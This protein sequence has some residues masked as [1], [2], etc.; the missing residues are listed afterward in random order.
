MSTP[1][2]TKKR[3][4][5][6]K[7]RAK[8]K[9][10]PRTTIAVASYVFPPAD[11][12]ADQSSPQ[13]EATTSEESDEIETLLRNWSRLHSMIESK[14]RPPVAESA[15]PGTPGGSTIKS[16]RTYANGILGCAE[17]LGKS[18]ETLVRRLE[19][20]RAEEARRAR[21]LEQENADLLDRTVLLRRSVPAM[22]RRSTMKPRAQPLIF[23]SY[24]I[25]TVRRV[26]RS[27]SNYVA[28]EAVGNMELKH[29]IAGRGVEKSRYQKHVKH[30]VVDV[31]AN[32]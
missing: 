21:M 1:A 18:L 30:V 6:T 20:E 16:R 7:V 17:R 9:T 23:S 2:I 8:A 27:V 5:S 13:D 12:P 26:P 28:V 24:K 3:R 32:L 31:S 15:P 4:V 14:H 10:T 22:L 11:N 25:D 29:P 19:S